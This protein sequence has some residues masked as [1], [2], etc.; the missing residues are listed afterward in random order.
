MYSRNKNVDIEF[1][2]RDV[3]SKLPSSSRFRNQIIQK[4]FGERKRK[5]RVTNSYYGYLQTWI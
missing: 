3:F 5:D 2:E 1:S 4:S